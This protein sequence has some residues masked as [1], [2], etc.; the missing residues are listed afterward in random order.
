MQRLKHLH[1][2]AKWQNVTEIASIFVLM[3]TH[4]AYYGN[5]LEEEGRRVGWSKEVRC[6]NDGYS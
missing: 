1:K 2:T 4:C 5:W 3:E 6:E